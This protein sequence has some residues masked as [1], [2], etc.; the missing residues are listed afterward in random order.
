MEFENDTNY[1]D[2]NF[3]VDKSIIN[4]IVDSAE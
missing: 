2:K 1:L 3:L 4:L